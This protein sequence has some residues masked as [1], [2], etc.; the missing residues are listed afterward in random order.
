M[1]AKRGGGTIL[2]P[3]RRKRSD[4]TRPPTIAAAG[5]ALQHG[6][7]DRTAGI[8]RP[9]AACRCTAPPSG[10]KGVRRARRHATGRDLHRTVYATRQHANRHACAYTHARTHAR[11]HTDARTHTCTHT[12]TYTHARTHKHKHTHAR[13]HTR[14]RTRAHTHTR[15]RAHTHARTH[16][17]TH[18]HVNADHTSG[19]HVWMRASVASIPLS[20][21]RPATHCTVASKQALSQLRTHA[22]GCVRVG[23][24]GGGKGGGGGSVREDDKGRL[25]QE[26]RRRRRRRSRQ[27]TPKPI[28]RGRYQ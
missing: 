12:R 16:A 13:T 19:T 2:P 7:L 27:S 26:R 11:M 6:R 22:D 10:P 9:L 18:R 28:N 15:A 20:T 3:V 1:R 4:A 8:G 5:Y 17:R 23:Q 21:P 24:G 25:L 14:T